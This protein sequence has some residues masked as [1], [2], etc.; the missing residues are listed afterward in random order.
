LIDNSG[1]LDDTRKQVDTIYQE[2]RKESQSIAS[3]RGT[4]QTKVADREEN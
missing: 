3:C 1:S 4:L 2:L